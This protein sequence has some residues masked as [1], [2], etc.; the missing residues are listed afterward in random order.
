MIVWQ[1]F[2]MEIT[3]ISQVIAD[4]TKLPYEANQCSRVEIKHVD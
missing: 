3:I 4:F 1:L 2:K